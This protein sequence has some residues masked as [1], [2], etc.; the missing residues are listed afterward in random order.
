[1]LLMLLTY[2]DTLYLATELGL[3]AIVLLACGLMPKHR[4]H[5]HEPS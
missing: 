2:H 4:H 5:K 3:L 1:M